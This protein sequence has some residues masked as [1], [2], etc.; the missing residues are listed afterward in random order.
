MITLFFS[1]TCSQAY[2]AEDEKYAENK[3]QLR[4]EISNLREKVLTMI[5]TNDQLPDIEKLERHEFILDTEEHQ[6]LQAEEEQMIQEVRDEEELSNLATMFTRQC[7]KQDCWDN[8]K[9][10]GIILK[11]QMSFQ[12][13]KTLFCSI[14]IVNVILSHS[15]VIL[16]YVTIL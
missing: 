9:V 3:A 13:K 14:M 16:K 12:K 8:M 15:R 5:A 4:Q 2:R 11:V 10:K 1:C 6:R 7:V